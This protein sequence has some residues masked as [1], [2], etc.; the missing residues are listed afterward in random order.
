[1]TVTATDGEGNSSDRDVKVMVTNM[2]EGGMVTLSRPR[3]RVG[4]S[5]MASLDDPDGGEANMKWQWW[6]TTAATLQDAP[7]VFTNEDDADEPDGSSWEKD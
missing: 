5:V 3:P 2:E 4:V 7:V 1:M 6:K